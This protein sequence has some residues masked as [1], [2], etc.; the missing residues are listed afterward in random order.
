[1]TSPAARARRHA[2]RAGARG[3]ARASRPAPTRASAA[4][5]S[6]PTAP[7]GRRGLAP[8]RRHHRT[9]RSTRCAR[10]GTPPAARPPSS[11]WSPATTPG[12]P[13]RARGR[14]SRPAYDGWCSPSATPT[15]SRA[16]ARPRCATPASRS[17]AAC[18]R[19]RR[20]GQPGVDLRHGPRPAVRDL[21]VRHHARRPQR[22]RRRHQPLGLLAGPRGSTPTGC[23]A[24]CDTMLVGT[25]HGR[26]RRPA[27]DGPRRRRPSRCRVQPLRAVM[28]LRDLPADRRVFDDAAETVHLRTRDPHEALKELF[29]LDRQHVFLEGGPTLAAAFWRPGVVDEVVT[30]V[31]P[32]L[33]GSGRAA[34]ADLGIGTIADAA[35]LTVTDVTRARPGA[36]GPTATRG[37]QRAPHA[38]SPAASED[39]LMFTGIVEELGTVAAVEDQGDAIRLTVRAAT[40]LEGTSPRR[41]DRRQRLLPDRGRR[42]PTGDTWTADVMQE[43]L[44]KTSLRGRRPRRPGQP[45]AGGDRR[46]APRRPPRPGPRRRRRHRRTPLAQRALGGRRG[47]PAGR[48]GQVRRRQGLD[49]RRRRLAHRRR[50]RRRLA[51]PSA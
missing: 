6:T 26:R 28:G 22:R 21:E 30:Y 4:C 24:L 33:L 31:A 18:S 25:E 15:R 51:S 37:H 39:D 45:R 5:C 12:A 19:T 13:V 49:L 47:L 27:A 10:P 46:Q 40:A 16:G 20:A 14:W 3:H 1:M 44:D 34:V 29:E 32:M 36:A 8:R 2:A 41:L 11:R 7:H 43:T 35:H 17:R 48:A 38:C 23:A 42:R 50:R 9:P